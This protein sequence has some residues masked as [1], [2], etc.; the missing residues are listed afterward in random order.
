MLRHR[1]KRR[2]RYRFTFTRGD[3]VLILRALSKAHDHESRHDVLGAFSR[4]HRRIS[5]AKGVLLP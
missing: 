2:L 5:D 3:V 4:L 1:A